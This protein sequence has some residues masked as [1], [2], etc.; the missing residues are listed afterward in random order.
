MFSNVLYSGLSCCLS[1]SPSVT[2]ATGST[3]SL[4]ESLLQKWIE[5]QRPNGFTVNHRPVERSGFPFAVRLTLPAPRQ[6]MPR[7]FFP[8]K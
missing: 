7:W 6:A 5:E 8:A 4:S 1:P 3:A 2:P